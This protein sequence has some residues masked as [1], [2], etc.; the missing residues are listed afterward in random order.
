[1][2]NCILL[3]N[4]PS[5][6]FLGCRGANQ[7]DIV[8]LVESSTR[9]GDSAFQKVKDFLYGFVSSLDVGINKVRIGLAKYSDET[10]TIFLLNDYSTKNE[11]LER[12]ESLSYTRGNSYTGRALETVN[13]RFFIESAGSRATDNIA[14]FLVVVTNGKSADEMKLPARELK[15]RG[16]YVYVT[17]HNIKDIAELQEV[18]SRPSRKFIYPQESFDAAEDVNTKLLKNV[19]SNIA[20]KI[21]GEQF[22]CYLASCQ[23]H[24]VVILCKFIHVI[25]L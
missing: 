6:F 21:Q 5:F 16:I 12:I 19:C 22:V 20:A 1:M 25:F 9:V 7:A 11:I 24:F 17:G 14:Q 8:F 3:I 4:Y 15:S 23:K 18:A 2:V 10:D 13:N